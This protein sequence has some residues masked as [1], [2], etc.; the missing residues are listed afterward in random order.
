MSRKL[1]ETCILQ[2]QIQTSSYS[3]DFMNNEKD[4]QSE[5]D[6]A[7]ERQNLNTYV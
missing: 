5:L 6:K 1:S 4:T 2:I 7:L 3:E